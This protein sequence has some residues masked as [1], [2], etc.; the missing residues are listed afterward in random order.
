MA[1]AI[2]IFHL[3]GGFQL[4]WSA[5]YLPITVVSLKVALGLQKKDFWV[6]QKDN[7]TSVTK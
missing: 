3:D 2:S 4:F 5:F 1:V 7:H 6:F